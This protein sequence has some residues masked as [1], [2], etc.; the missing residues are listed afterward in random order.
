M[1]LHCPVLPTLVIKLPL[2]SWLGTNTGVSLGQHPSVLPMQGSL[3]SLEVCH[4]T[5]RLEGCGVLLTA[6]SN[7]TLLNNV[8]IPIASTTISCC[9]CCRHSYV[10]RK[11][12][13][14]YCMHYS[15]ENLASIPLSSC[16]S[17]R[18]SFLHWKI[19]WSPRGHQCWA[20]A[21]HCVCRLKSFCWHVP[22]LCSMQQLQTAGKSAVLCRWIC[23]TNIASSLSTSHG[24]LTSF[25]K[26]RT[27][28]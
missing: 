28:S 9:H 15:T 5:S 21:Q 26:Q 7:L 18:G 3:H 16:Q 24:P 11:Y 1:D 20:C 2:H 8:I 13:R 17:D 19:F 12:I 25:C 4:T 27:V 14:K 23:I 10:L 6:Q 22:A